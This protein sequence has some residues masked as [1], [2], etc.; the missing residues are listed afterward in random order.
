MS[1]LVPDFFTLQAGGWVIFWVLFFAACT[2]GNAGWM[3]AIMCIHM[4]PYADSSPPCSTGHL[5]RQL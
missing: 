2:Y 3:R 4:C 1:S 5:H